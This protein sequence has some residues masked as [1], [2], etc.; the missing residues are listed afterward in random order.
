MILIL[1][2]CMLPTDINALKSY[3]CEQNRFRHFK[4]WSHMTCR[5]LS[6]FRELDISRICHLF[7]VDTVERQH[8]LCNLLHVSTQSLFSKY[9]LSVIH[10][11]EPQMSL[12]PISVPGEDSFSTVS[13]PFSADTFPELRVDS[14]CVKP[15]KH[16]STYTNI[17]SQRELP[18]RKNTLRDIM[19]KLNFCKKYS[20]L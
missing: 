2:L 17:S 12:H 18:F 20:R 16:L 3:K 13:L 14:S 9:T 19:L 11:H 1:V 15:L 8:R 6:D 5:N 4:K 7:G 10:T